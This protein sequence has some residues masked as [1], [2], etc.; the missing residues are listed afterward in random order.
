MRLRSIPPARRPPSSSAHHASGAT[1]RTWQ[2]RQ[3]PRVRQTVSRPPALHPAQ[4][5]SAL[6]QQ[7]AFL[8]E[9]LAHW[10]REFDDAALLRLYDQREELVHILAAIRQP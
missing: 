2:P 4:I 7:I 9:E 1:R 10:A 6:T 3:V 8:G 5:E